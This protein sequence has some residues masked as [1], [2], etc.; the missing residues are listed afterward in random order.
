[1]IDDGIRAINLR[2]VVRGR[3]HRREGRD[4]YLVCAV[5][6]PNG[7]TSA[8]RKYWRKTTARPRRVSKCRPVVLNEIGL[9]TGS[10][11]F[12]R[13]TWDRPQPCAPFLSRSHRSRKQRSPYNPSALGELNRNDNGTRPSFSERWKCLPVRVIN[14]KA[15]AL[16]GKEV[17]RHLRY[18][19][20]LPDNDFY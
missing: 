16:N 3:Y 12:M 4:L 1:M 10:L 17:L 13:I 8:R 15:V 6:P 2:L 11:R 14:R 18:G 19:R 9:A 7:Q 20:N 5:L